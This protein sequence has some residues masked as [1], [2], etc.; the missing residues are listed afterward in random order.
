M[1]RAAD[2]DR[3]TGWVRLHAAKGPMCNLSHLH[4]EH[5]SAIQSDGTPVLAPASWACQ[6]VAPE[7]ISSL[8]CACCRTVESTISRDVGGDVWG[9]P[10]TSLLYAGYLG[11]RA[12][13]EVRTTEWVLH[14][15]PVAPVAPLDLL[16]AAPSCLSFHTVLRPLVDPCTTPG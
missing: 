8:A 13:Q 2:T 7:H 5:A 4:R 14:V 16:V 15:A 11:P 1:Q 6:G 10:G 9:C 12:L 3:A